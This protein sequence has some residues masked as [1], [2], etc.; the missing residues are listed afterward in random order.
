MADKIKEIQAKYKRLQRRLPRLVGQEAVNFF[1]GNFRLQGFKDGG[2][3]RKWGRRKGG[4]KSKRAILTGSG[5]LRKSINVI[6]AG[7]QT[8]TV[9]SMGVPY[10]QI[11]N[12]GG[13]MDV[14]I[15]QRKYFWAKYYETDNDMYK[16]MALATK[17]RIS[18]RQFIGDSSDLDQA[19]VRMIRLQLLKAF[20]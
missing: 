14:S 18:K 8:I 4:D 5:R 7:Q 9:G 1:R 16:Y 19:I 10:A 20:K 17:I 11:H 2:R 15:K 12:E 3:V 6:R 13:S